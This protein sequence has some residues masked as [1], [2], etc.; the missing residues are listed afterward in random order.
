MEEKIN[1]LLEAF[2]GPFKADGGDIEIVRIDGNTLTVRIVIGPTGCRECITPPEVV[3][4]ILA[5]NIKERLG[6]DCKIKV[7]VSDLSGPHAE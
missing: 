5:S 7:E 2:R 6:L 4:Q 3:E 1:E